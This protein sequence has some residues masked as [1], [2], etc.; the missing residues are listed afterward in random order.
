MP[1]GV[2]N[3][4]PIYQKAVTKAFHEHIDVFMKIFLDN[5]LVFNDL[6]THLEKL[7]KCF[8]KCR[9]FGIN[10][11]PNKYAFM[12]FLVTILSFIMFKESEVMDPKKVGAL[13]NMAIPIVPQE[14][15]FFN[16]MAQ[17]YM[18][19]IKNFA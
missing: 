17:F 15:Q 4:P 10:L 5:F 6:S 9:E 18:C 7:L 13:I 2:K 8:L 12:V 19:F 3:E 16:G 11:N 14:I 1:F